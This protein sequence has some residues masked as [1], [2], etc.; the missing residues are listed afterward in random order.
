MFR[1]ERKY[2]FK[3]NNNFSASYLNFFLKKRNINVGHASNIINN[4]YFD[5]ID[6]KNYHLHINGNLDRYKIRVRWYAKQFQ[7][8]GNFY[9]EVKRRI[10]KK[11]I[12][13]KI[14]LPIKSTKEFKNFDFGYYI[15]K[16]ND[17]NNFEKRKLNFKPILFNIYKRFYYFYRKKNNRITVDTNLTFSNCHNFDST[18]YKSTE[19]K[20]LEYK[21][22]NNN[23][24]PLIS[25]KNLKLMSQ[26]FSKY[27]FGLEMLNFKL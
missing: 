13:N 24:N 25:S 19:I 1:F 9:L 12:K 27:L 3:N 5:S 23:L 2:Q 6:L 26:N 21:F 15:N 10:N 4:L 11:I 22:E 14:L 18:F 17:K 16:L 7:K 8:D 20:V